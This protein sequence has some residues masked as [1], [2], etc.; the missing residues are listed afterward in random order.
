MKNAMCVQNKSFKNS[1]N[2][3]SLKTKQMGPMPCAFR[4]KIEKRKYYHSLNTI[5]QGQY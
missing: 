2:Y 4:L 3:N 5:S 1:N